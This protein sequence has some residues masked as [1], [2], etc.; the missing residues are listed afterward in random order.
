MNEA[1]LQLAADKRCLTLATT[2]LSLA[3]ALTA[4]TSS[5]I[6]G[7]VK[8]AQGRGI[9]D[10]QLGLFRQDSSTPLTVASG[11]GGAYSF[12]DVEPGALVLEVRKQRF[13][14]RTVNLQVDKGRAQVLDVTLDVAGVNE[15]VIVTAAGEAQT[16]DEVS[17]AYSNISHD[18]IV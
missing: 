10:A 11:E 2:L 16:A 3:C 13:R 14:S 12:D 9:A 1:R 18:E 4:Q 7:R 8:D 5:G 6:S 17:K 15:T